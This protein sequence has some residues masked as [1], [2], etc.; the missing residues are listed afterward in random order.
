[1][2][3]ISK[4][5]ELEKLIADLKE[6]GMTIGFTPTMGALHDGHFSLIKRSVEEN[7]ISICSIFVNP[8][9]F[10]NA[11]DL[12][13]YP[14]TLEDDCKGLEKAGCD[15][16]FTPGISDIYPGGEERFQVDID[17]KI[18]SQGRGYVAGYGVASRA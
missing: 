4:S 10:N 16:V 2:K 5:A 11:E 3:V 17:L 15:V 18:V 8:T 14:R 7:D 9:Q 12:D 1:M 6:Q 13:K